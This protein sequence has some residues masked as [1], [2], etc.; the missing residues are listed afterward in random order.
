MSGMVMLL[1]AQNEGAMGG[2]RYGSLFP[3]AVQKKKISV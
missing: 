1:H 2:F 3:L